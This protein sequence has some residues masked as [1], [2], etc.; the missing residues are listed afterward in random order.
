MYRYVKS[1]VPSLHGHFFFYF[2]CNFSKY[3]E[4]LQTA[5]AISDSL[6]NKNVSK[7]TET[8]LQKQGRKKKT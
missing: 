7:K 6:S 8:Q 4:E 5:L 3:E 1:D 2:I